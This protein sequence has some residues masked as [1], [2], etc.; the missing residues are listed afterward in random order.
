MSSRPGTSRTLFRLLFDDALGSP[1]YLVDAQVAR[2][3]VPAERP[4]RID[5][6]QL[7]GVRDVEQ[8]PLGVLGLTERHLEAADREIANRRARP[9]Q[10]NP[11]RGID[12]VVLARR[13]E[14]LRRVV[15]RIHCD[16]H[17]TNG[18]EAL[19]PEAI[20]EPRQILHQRRA[21]RRTAGEEEARD[22]DVP[23]KVIAAEGLAGRI[24]ER[25]RRDLLQQRGGTRY[26]TQRRA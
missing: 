25:E 14:L 16:G 9:G 10:Q 11:A 23:A 12:P 17:Q 8:T 20:L 1:E 24:D 21:D 18:V 3:V 7:P 2:I 22:V 5:E 6:Q 19:P 15:L 4:A 13:P 26:A